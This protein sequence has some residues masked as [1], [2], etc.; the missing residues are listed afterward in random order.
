MVSRQAAIGIDIANNG[1]AC[2]ES[3]FTYVRDRLTGFSQEHPSK[4]ALMADMTAF[5]SYLELKSAH[6]S[7]N[8][9]SLMRAPACVG[10]ISHGGSAPIK[11][12]VDALVSAAD[13]HAFAGLFCTAASP[14]IV[15]AA[16]DNRFY[17]SEEEYLQALGKALA[18]EYEA[19]LSR[20]LILQ[21]DAPDLAME[22]HCRF[23]QRPL[24]DFLTFAAG[25]V[26]TI[27]GALAPF[28]AAG[29][30]RTRL[31]VCW[32]NYDGPHHLDVPLEAIL[33]VLTDA[34]VGAFLLSGANPRHAHE[35]RLLARLP[36]RFGVIAGVI[37]TTTNYV[38]HPEV[39]ADRILAVVNSV[40]D[41]TRVQAATDCGFATSAG[42]GDVA[43]EVAWLKLESLVEG[44]SLASQR[45]GLE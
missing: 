32:G 44:A 39:V 42:F 10:P 7:R 15:A 30:A 36:E 33:D 41:P 14:G 38:E 6:R 25:I 18:P 40:S 23:A 3:F 4:R 24:E 17:S 26:A 9:V 34:R 29:A 2:R 21:I 35:H 37:D 1:E 31:H 13:G 22:R 5:P 27:N 8:A 16:M 11:A 19:I 43:R 12:E 28:G 45:L 20:G